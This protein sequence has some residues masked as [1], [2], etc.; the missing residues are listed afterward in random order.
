M[1]KDSILII[2]VLA[3]LDMSNQKLATAL[4]VPR[5]RVENWRYKGTSVP[6]EVWRDICRLLLANYSE[7][8]LQAAASRVLDI[9][10]KARKAESKTK[11]A[12]KKE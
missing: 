9:M 6:A 12:T 5:S 10:S 3:A 11:D 2:D 8:N 4:N 7:K 1:E